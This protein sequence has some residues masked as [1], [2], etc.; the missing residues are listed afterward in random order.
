MASI[1]TE[2]AFYAIKAS[3]GMLVF[4]KDDGKLL[5]KKIDK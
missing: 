1:F 3:I 5:Y 2:Y 4:N